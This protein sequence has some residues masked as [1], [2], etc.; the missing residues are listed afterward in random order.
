MQTLARI[1]LLALAVSAQTFTYTEQ[2]DGS[3][4][5]INDQT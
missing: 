4:L 3:F 2:D 5:C 1:S